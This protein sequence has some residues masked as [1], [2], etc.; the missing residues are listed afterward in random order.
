MGNLLSCSK[1]MEQ[2]HHS[3]LGSQRYLPRNAPANIFLTPRV[4]YCLHQDKPRLQGSRM[5]VCSLLGFYAGFHGRNFK[6]LSCGFWDLVF[7]A[8]TKPLSSNS[9]KGDGRKG[10]VQGIPENI[11]RSDKQNKD[12]KRGL[13]LPNSHR[14]MPTLGTGF[15]SL[16]SQPY[17]PFPE[18][19]SVIS[20]R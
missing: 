16:C 13:D 15:L 7:T 10:D 4:L 12:G 19:L 18:G 2:M 8:V 6:S 17:A 9:P 1:K 3:L 20:P 11:L 5:G 14:W